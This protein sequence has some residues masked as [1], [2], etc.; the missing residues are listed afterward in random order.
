MSV[1]S[2]NA[3]KTT[4]KPYYQQTSLRSATKIMNLYIGFSLFKRN[5]IYN[6]TYGRILSSKKSILTADMYPKQV[7]EVQ[8]KLTECP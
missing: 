3:T 4:G 7:R 2:I 5:Y 6:L 8:S 1:I